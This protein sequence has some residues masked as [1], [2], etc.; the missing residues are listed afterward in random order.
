MTKFR[1][2]PV[3]IDAVKWNGADIGLTDGKE[4]SAVER[5]EMPD[6]LPA[7]RVQSEYDG[8]SPENTDCSAQPGEVVRM[9]DYLFIG[10]LEGTH[11]A[12]PGDWIIRGVKGEIYPCKNDVFLLTYEAAE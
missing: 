5:L 10:T 1:K 12:N 9:G 8:G 7:A 4:P 3:V 2:K 11:K 6:W